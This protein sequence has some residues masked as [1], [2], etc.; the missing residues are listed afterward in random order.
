MEEN[1]SLLQ[2]RADKLERLALLD[3]MEEGPSQLVSPIGFGSHASSPMKQDVFNFSLNFLDG[4][5]PSQSIDEGGHLP[6]ATTT[7]ETSSSTKLDKQACRH[8]IYASYFPMNPSEM[9]AQNLNQRSVVLCGTGHSRAQIEEVVLE[10]RR[11]AEMVVQQLAKEGSP[12]LLNSVIE[13]MTQYKLLPT[14]EQN[15]IACSCVQLLLSPVDGSWSFPSCSQLVFVC[16]MLELAGSF[17]QMIQL[18]IE[19]MTFNEERKDTH[20]QVSYT[21]L[22]GALC[23]IVV[24]IFWRYSSVLFLSLHDTMVVYERYMNVDVWVF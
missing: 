19:L 24:N 13:F 12:V 16:E 11:K 23:L 6:S 4:S 17:H 2:M 3:T 10:M 1:P 9:S 21:P 7:T 20:K 8:L 22:P 14:F 18:L 15:Y 5:S